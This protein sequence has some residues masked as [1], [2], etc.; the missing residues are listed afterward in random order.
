M[1]FRAAL[2]RF[3]GALKPGSPFATAFMSGSHGYPVAGTHF[4]ALPITQDD[5]RRH[6]TELGV[7][8]LS[9]ELLQTKHRVRDG[10]AGMIVATGVVRDS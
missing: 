3:T 5:V 8:D 2:A 9:V 4:P 6:F 7:S 1:E 10:Y